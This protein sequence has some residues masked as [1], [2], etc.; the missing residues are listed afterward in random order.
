MGCVAWRVGSQSGADR[1][2]VR[3]SVSIVNRGLEQ[4]PSYITSDILIH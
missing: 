4:L 3:L 1:A 2:G